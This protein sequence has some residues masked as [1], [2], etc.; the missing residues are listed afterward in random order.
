MHPL[1]FIASD[2]NEGDCFLIW[3]AELFSIRP[4]DHDFPELILS[5]FLFVDLLI[6]NEQPSACSIGDS[7]SNERSPEETKDEVD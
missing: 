6:V 3:S 4:L 7:I 5:Y 2:K 1:G